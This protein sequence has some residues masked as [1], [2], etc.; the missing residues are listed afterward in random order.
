M[1]GSDYEV[2][3]ENFFYY[4][5]HIVTQKIIIFVLLQN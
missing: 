3:S 2:A 1:F 5:E 4:Q